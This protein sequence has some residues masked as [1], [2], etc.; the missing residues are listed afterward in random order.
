MSE[1][2]LKQLEKH[3]DSLV[4]KYDQFLLGVRENIE[5]FIEI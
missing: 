3:F 4:D 5:Q 1:S 2:E